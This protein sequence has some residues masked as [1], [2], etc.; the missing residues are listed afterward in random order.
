MKANL[1]WPPAIEERGND[2]AGASVLA[3]YRR[4]S[5][6]VGVAID[7]DDRHAGFPALTHQIFGRRRRGQDE[8]VDLVAEECLDLRIGRLAGRSGKEQDVAPRRAQALGELLDHLR[9]KWILQTADRE[10]DDV[11]PFC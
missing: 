9:I 1:L 10:P 5:R 2:L 8:S 3:A 6:Q 7:K 11:G 4:N